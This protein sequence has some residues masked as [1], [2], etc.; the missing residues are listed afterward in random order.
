MTDK[1]VKELL[2]KDTVGSKTPI[3]FV[4]HLKGEDETI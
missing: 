3:G 4:N 1:E 2:N